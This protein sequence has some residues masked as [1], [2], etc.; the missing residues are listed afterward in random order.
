MQMQG[1]ALYVR[2]QRR[3]NISVPI[4]GVRGGG[5]S[6]AIFNLTL[7]LCITK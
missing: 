6:E 1:A 4:N 5:G 7:T 2:L 3:A